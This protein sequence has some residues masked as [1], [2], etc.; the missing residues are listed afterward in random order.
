MEAQLRKDAAESREK[1][2]KEKEDGTENPDA[3]TKESRVQIYEEMQQ[4][5]EEEEKNMKKN[6]MFKDF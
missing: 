3:Y 6:S 5:K 4:K 2:R 1:K